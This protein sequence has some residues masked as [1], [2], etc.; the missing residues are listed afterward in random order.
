MPSMSR[1]QQPAAAH[2]HPSSVQRTVLLIWDDVLDPLAA[3]AAGPAPETWGSETLDKLQ[4]TACRRIHLHMPGFPT[5]FVTRVGSAL[6]PSE[7]LLPA[8]KVLVCQ[9]NARVLPGI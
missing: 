5:R 6:P 7:V 1:A 3:R 8:H 4:V 2:C 9:L